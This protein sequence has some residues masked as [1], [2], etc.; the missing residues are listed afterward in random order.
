[1]QAWILRYLWICVCS[2]VF[3]LT[4]LSMVNL[5]TNNHIHVSTCN[6]AGLVKTESSG[7]LIETMPILLICW[8]SFGSAGHALLTVSSGFLCSPDSYFYPKPP[9]PAIIWYSSVSPGY[10]IQ[11]WWQSDQVERTF[12]WQLG[13]KNSRPAWLISLPSPLLSLQFIIFIHKM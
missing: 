12:N 1:M 5:I 9:W 4:V 8:T 7:L 13:N 11:D 2:S 10:K 3:T 6:V